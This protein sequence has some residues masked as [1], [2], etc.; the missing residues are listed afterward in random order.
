MAKNHLNSPSIFSKSL[1]VKTSV[2]SSLTGGYSGSG[3]K[4]SGGRQSCTN[5]G[6]SLDAS[7]A[8]ASSK[9]SSCN[10]AQIERRRRRKQANQRRFGFVNIAGVHSSL[11]Y[12]FSCKV[13]QY[14][15]LAPLLMGYRYSYPYPVPLPLPLPFPA[16]SLTLT[17][18][19]ALLH[20]PPPLLFALALPLP[21]PLTL[22]LSFSLTSTPFLYPHPSS[23]LYPYPYSR[24]LPLTI[25]L[26]IP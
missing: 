17:L 25:P 23:S 24:L 15:L 18:T 14:R 12:L 2:D 11:F 3:A 26:P 4:M 1:L 20:L 21:K 9:V 5:S 19:L 8:V 13:T 7:A 10:A 16:H 6:Y 22:P